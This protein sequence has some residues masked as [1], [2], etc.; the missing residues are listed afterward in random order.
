MCEFD[1]ARGQKLVCG[2][3]DS[4]DPLSFFLKDYP[5]NIFE[6]KTRRPISSYREGG[7]EMGCWQKEDIKPYICCTHPKENTQKH[8]TQPENGIWWTMADE[9]ETVKLMHEISIANFS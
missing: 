9:R 4:L 8:S 6:R 2:D 5:C 3:C 1:Q 7:K